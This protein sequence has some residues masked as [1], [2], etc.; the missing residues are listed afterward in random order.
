M[1]IGCQGRVHGP[2][3][4]SRQYDA[5]DDFA[6]YL[7][8]EALATYGINAGRQDAARSVVARGGAVVI[9][10]Q[11]VGLA[12]EGSSHR[13]VVDRLPSPVNF[14]RI[15]FA[16]SRQGTLTWSGKSK[17][18]ISGTLSCAAAGEHNAAPINHTPARRGEL[19]MV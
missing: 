19:R 18:L 13:Q 6:V 5:V 16:L 10:G 2:A 9:G 11:P 12:V 17:G 14:I 3:I 8:V 1:V 15:P 4:A 7:K